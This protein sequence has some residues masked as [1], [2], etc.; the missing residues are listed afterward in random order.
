MSTSE[1]SA[2]VGRVIDVSKWQ[3]S[4]PNLSGVLGVIARAGIGTKPDLMFTT[5]IANAR[6]AGKW[7]GSYWYNW[8]DLSVSDQVTA[9]IARE[10]AVGGVSLHVI[11]WEGQEG[12]TKGQTADFIRIYRARTGNKI[13]LYAS[14]SWFTDVGQDWNWIAN[15]SR[16]PIKQWDMWQYGPYLGV[17]GNYAKQAILDL[18]KE[19]T[20]VTPLPVTDQTPKLVS[21]N[22]KTNFYDLDGETVIRTAESLGPDRFSPYGAGPILGNG[23]AEFR[24]VYSNKRVLLVR[25]SVWKDIPAPVEDCTAEVAAATVALQNLADEQASLIE[26]LKVANATAIAKL[27]AAAETER[28]RIALALGAQ[29]ADRVRSA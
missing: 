20:D 21:K 5:H 4:L 7:V 26:G 25:P 16:Q 18:V 1:P 6:R 11:D 28:E 24:A 8:G 13:G 9:Y 29:E 10:E 23:E 19:T 14:E 17:D 2:S 27:D 15:Y 22:T 3:T 12:F